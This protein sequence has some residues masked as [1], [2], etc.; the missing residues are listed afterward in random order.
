[1]ARED[2][3]LV[4]PINFGMIMPNVYRSGCPTKE[5]F[6]FLKRLGLRCVLYVGTET[7]PA[8]YDLMKRQEIVEKMLVVPMEAN[9]EPFITVPPEDIS[10]ALS[11]L[12]NKELHPVLL[13]SMKGRNRAGVIVGCLRK[14][15]GWSLV[16]IYEEYD[17]YRGSEK[18][19]AVDKRYI[20]TFQPRITYRPETL[21]EGWSLSYVR[22]GYVRITEDSASA[23]EQKDPEADEADSKP[24]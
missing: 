2:V 11:I 20:E 8:G 15:Q 21:P 5:N 7:L 10:N 19:P 18:G 14:L 6:P 4:P 16:S 17:R 23:L 1:M 24:P 12:L 22:D 3:V 13:H 9:K